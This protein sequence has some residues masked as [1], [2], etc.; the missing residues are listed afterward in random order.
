MELRSLHQEM[1]A[2]VDF[3]RTTA[4][5]DLRATAELAQNKAGAKTCMLVDDLQKRTREITKKQVE[6]DARAMI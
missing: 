2:H 1:P 5:R 3:T 4:L 6:H